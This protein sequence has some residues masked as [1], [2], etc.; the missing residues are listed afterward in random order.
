MGIAD[1]PV[2]LGEAWRQAV[3]HAFLA[4]VRDGTVPSAHFDAWLAQDYLYVGDLLWWQAR[5]LARAPRAAQPVLVDGCAALVAEL[6]WF[7][8]RAAGRGVPL[9]VDRAPSTVEYRELLGRLDHVP[10]PVALAAL[11]A[12][13]RVYLDAWRYAAPAAPEFGEFVEHWTSPEFASYVD[14]LARVADSH[15]AGPDGDAVVAEIV[16]AEARFWPVLTR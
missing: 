14:S 7:E 5:L 8:Q 2:R 1:T 15:P 9:T 11:W 4:G 3:E 10:T 13:E 6:S 16:A 12:T